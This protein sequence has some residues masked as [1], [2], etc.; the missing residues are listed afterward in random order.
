MTDTQGVQLLDADAR[1]R[2]D[3]D[4]FIRKV[5]QEIP[6]SFLDDLREKRLR[7]AN[8]KSGDLHHVARIPTALAE[9]WMAEGFNIFD[10]NVTI[11]EIVKRLHSEDMAA[12]MATT[13]QV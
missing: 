8:A 4:R 2:I 11:A 12:F 10:K 6:T 1:Y 13:K 7:S 9:K 3:T 5:T